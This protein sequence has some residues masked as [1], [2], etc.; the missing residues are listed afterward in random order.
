MK[1]II[2]ALA[3]ILF[4]FNFNISMAEQRTTPWMDITESKDSLYSYRMGSFDS[5][6][7]KGGKNVSSIVVQIKNK[8]ENSASYQKYYVSNEHCDLGM[9]K[10]IA[11]DMN[12]EFIY[13]ND[14]VSSGNSVSSGISD[15]ICAFYKLNKKEK[16]DKGI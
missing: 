6:T 14:F 8:K 11:L 13:E 16:Q 10:L 9:G 2:L 5:A 3:A 12:G 1:K 4:S 15:F 7:T